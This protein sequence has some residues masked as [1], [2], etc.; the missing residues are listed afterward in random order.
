MVW[1][2]SANSASNITYTTF[3]VTNKSTMIAPW[4]PIYFFNKL[5]DPCQLEIWIEQ[6]DN[7]LTFFRCALGQATCRYS[8][9]PKTKQKKKPWWRPKGDVA[10]LKFQNDSCSPTVKVTCTARET[11]M[12]A[13][14]CILRGNL[15]TERWCQHKING[16]WGEVSHRSAFEG[17]LHHRNL[18]LSATSEWVSLPASLPIAWQTWKT[19]S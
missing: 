4:T 7:Q 16:I 14:V 18:T 11:R 10:I 2:G 9:I 8:W 15:Q 6:T 1:L 5:H 3:V 12:W 17:K 13:N 19:G